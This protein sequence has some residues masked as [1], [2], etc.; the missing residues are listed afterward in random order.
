MNGKLTGCYRARVVDV[1]HPKSLMMARVSVDA[2]WH[3]VPDDACPWA[4][5]NLEIGGAFAPCKIGDLVWVDFPYEGDSRRPRIIGACQDAPGGEPNVPPESWGGADAYQP[6]EIDDAPPLR[7][8]KPTED[9]VYNRNGLLE[10]RTGGGGWSVTHLA[11]DTTM[12][13]NENGQIFIISS[14]NVFVQ[15]ATGVKVKSGADLELEAAG[16]IKL[17][18][19]GMVEST[20]GSDTEFKSVGSFSVNSGQN[21]K[22]ISEGSFSATSGKNTEIISGMSFN[23]TSKLVTFMQG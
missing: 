8:L 20:A 11:S 3:G 1:K 10:I 15:G 9:Y 13:M 19:G 16:D 4:E 7:E 2:L 22:I 14:Q 18:A 12:G 17:K 6:P 23:S 5:Y 21:T